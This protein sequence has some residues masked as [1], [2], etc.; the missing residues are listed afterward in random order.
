[1]ILISDRNFGQIDFIAKSIKFGKYLVL[2]YKLLFMQNS[3]NVENYLNAKGIKILLNDPNDEIVTEEGALKTM[4]SEKL[5]NN[6]IECLGNNVI[7]LENMEN[8]ESIDSLENTNITID[9]SSSYNENQIEIEEDISEKNNI[10]NN[11]KKIISLYINNKDKYKLI[12]E[13]KKK[14][15][16]AKAKNSSMLDILLSSEKNNFISNLIN[17]TKF[18]ISQNSSQINNNQNITEFINQKITEIFQNFKSAGDTLYRMTKINNSK[19]NYTLFIENFFNNLFIW[20][21]YDK[22]DDY[23]CIYIST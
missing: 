17:I 5:C 14:E 9:N 10:Y 1:M 21:T 11:N 7:E 18:L 4:I 20:G 6:L 22:L 3:R 15:K 13:N 19:Y 12:N 23:G 16:I 8:S 2:I